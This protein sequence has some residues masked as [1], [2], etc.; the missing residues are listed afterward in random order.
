MVLIANLNH[1]KLTTAEFGKKSVSSLFRYLTAVTDLLGSQ[2]YLDKFDADALSS[3]QEVAFPEKPPAPVSQRLCGDLFF[4]L[5]P[6]GP[7]NFINK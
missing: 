2:S 6:V 7:Q 3:E 1:L 4:P 5:S